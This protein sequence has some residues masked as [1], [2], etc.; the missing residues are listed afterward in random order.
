MREK[1]KKTLNELKKIR[2]V[3]AVFLFGSYAT[4]KQLP[5]SD[6]DICVVTEKI[7]EEI[8]AEITSL[9]SEKIDVCFFW[10]LPITI[11]YK[12]LKEGKPLLERD[13]KFLHEVRFKT[14]REYIEFRPILRRFAE[15][16]K[17][18]I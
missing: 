13:E 7:D 10:D 5:F 14:V 12:V 17:I 18:K 9:S 4:G 1:I 16:F 11:R 8:K 15:R 2:E 6:V 3:K